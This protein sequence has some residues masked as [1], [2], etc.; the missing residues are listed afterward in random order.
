MENLR[1]DRSTYARSQGDSSRRGAVA[2]IAIL[3]SL[4]HLA[5]NGRYG[6]H[7]DELQFLSD[8]Q[9]L[10][11][12]FVSYPPFTPF[13]EHL[14]T[15]LF[16]RWLIGL[17]FFSVL[18]QAFSIF[19]A[20]EITRELG[21]KRLAQ[22]T[23]AL[24]L[25]FSPLPLFQGTEFQYSSFDYLWWVLLSFLVLK[26][27]TS[28]NPLWMPLI[29]LT[30]GLGLITKYSILFFLAGILG[31][32]VFTSERRYFKSLW[33]WIAILLAL[34]ICLPNLLWQAHHN[35]ISFHFLRHIH[36]RDVAQG[37]AKHFLS[38][39]FLIC[40]NLIAAPLWLAGL[41]AYVRN[42]SYRMLAWMYLIP[43]ALFL[44][45][46]GRGYYL[47][48]AYPLLIA[49]G[50]VTAEFWLSKLRKGY[51]WAITTA[52]FSLFFCCGMYIW[53][54]VLP[55]ASSGPL[56]DFA[57]SKN[58]DL[59]EEIGWGDLVQTVTDIYISLP[60]EQRQRTGILVGNYGEQGAIEI[61]G[62][63]YGL[64]A[65]I[66]GTNS[67]W[68]RGYPVPPPTKLIVLGLSKSYVAKTF[69]SC[70]LAGENKNQEN[71]QNEESQFHPDIFLCG[72]PKAG[73]ENFWREFQNFG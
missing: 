12:G 16:G 8:A 23:T 15:V 71:I 9:H 55:L 54:I 52:Y 38:D 31:G 35:F 13:V 63:S 22:I 20:G 7:R 69:N 1:P 47:A 73:W 68:F 51:V 17:R 27:L 34:L 60:D 58:G 72:E 59:R 42:R 32:L 67:A 49:G 11:W 53:A 57:L 45:T 70:E 46:K 18:A 6:F 10:D 3:I 61:L 19:L 28:K 26:L 4:V 64:P 48:A 43:L 25:A 50:A 30:A 56:R 65:P 14:A 33:F 41:A 39:Q 29:G 5:T 2:T 24:T 37:R 21:G 62:S 36:L 40:V 66:S 44:V